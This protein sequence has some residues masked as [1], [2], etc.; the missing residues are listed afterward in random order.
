ME[1]SPIAGNKERSMSSMWIVKIVVF[2]NSA[3]VL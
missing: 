3:I 2:S 1:N